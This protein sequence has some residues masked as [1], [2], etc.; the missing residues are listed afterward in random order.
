MGS[1]SV[2]RSLFSRKPDKS[3]RIVGKDKKSASATILEGTPAKATT[4]SS[5]PSESD[6]A[7][8][9]SHNLVKSPSS[10]ADYQDETG[11]HSL[12]DIGDI[13]A[14]LWTRAFELFRKRDH[15]AAMKEYI[16]CLGSLQDDSQSRLLSRSY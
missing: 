10:L 7:I 5:S 12:S 15:D 3:G 16:G 4:A 13:R 6:S 8:S 2:I 11:A 14:H 9:A 1:K